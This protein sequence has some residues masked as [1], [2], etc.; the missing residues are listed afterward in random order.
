MIN[1]LL[2]LENIIEDTISTIFK[3]FLF[4][5]LI[6]W[7][8]IIFGISF[9]FVFFMFYRIM[10][11][12]FYKL[13]PLSPFD[14][15]F[16]SKN[17]NNRNNLIGILELS[18]FSFEKFEKL[19]K[20]IIIRIKKMRVKLKYR[21]FN[22]YW[23]EVKLSEALKTIEKKEMNKENLTNYLNEQMSIYIDIFNKLPFQ[24]K[25]I[26][27]INLNEGVILF[28]FDHILSDSFS[29]ISLM[30]S[31]DDN[32]SFELIQNE[33]E[34]FKDSKKEKLL[35]WILFPFYGPYTLFLLFLNITG[36]KIS[37]K[38]K[39]KKNNHLVFY[40][41]K[42]S[43][44]K[45]NKVRKENNLSFNQS[46][47]AIL[48]NAYY[49]IIFEK[50]K[51]KNIYKFIKCIILFWRKYFPLKINDVILLNSTGFN[52]Q[53]FNLI[54][55]MNL[56]EIIKNPI[57]EDFSINKVNNSYLNWIILIREFFSFRIFNLI[58]KLI[59][60]KEEIIIQNIP[61]SKR[62]IIIEQSEVK[63]IFLFQN[64][65]IPLINVISYNN[66]FNINLVIDNNFEIK[67]EDIIQQIDNLINLFI[68]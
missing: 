28:K 37:K 18:D 52:F 68:K 10:I 55:K 43:L 9:F 63:N 61:G 33:K 29:L 23:E 56:N 35:N 42:H 4:Y 8:G 3:I 36:T 60:E 5:I 22:Y 50:N 2:E 20:T 24:I 32:Y 25:L 1:F 16:L 30:Y 11:Y 64:S 48:F 51:E 12:K 39:N 13:I 31:L 40:G 47:I 34:I 58:K 45:F 62:K 15:C 44:N 38:N 49:N 21:F 53:K 41:K 7:Y 14:I 65:Q 46:L 59:I 27:F 17:E 57:K 6:K 66:E 54:N 67:G 26:K 19:M